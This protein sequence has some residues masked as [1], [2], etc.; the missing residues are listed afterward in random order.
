MAALVSSKCDLYKVYLLEGS[1][2]T[3][4]QLRHWTEWTFAH[5]PWNGDSSNPNQ[6]L[7]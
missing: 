6:T 5:P 3:H 2:S 7:E 1:A 4:P